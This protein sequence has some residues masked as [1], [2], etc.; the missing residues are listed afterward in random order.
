M[1]ESQG[2]TVNFV[3]KFNT[4]ESLVQIP[5]VYV[6]YIYFHCT[7]SVNSNSGIATTIKENAYLV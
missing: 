5:S 7:K 3:E 4:K 6:L 1:R 2:Q